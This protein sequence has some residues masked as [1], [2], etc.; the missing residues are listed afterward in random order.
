MAVVLTGARIALLSFAVGG[1][2]AAQPIPPLVELQTIHDGKLS[3]L[4]VGAV[5]VGNCFSPV[6]LREMKEVAVLTVSVNGP[7]ERSAEH[8]A[9]QKAAEAGANCLQPLAS[10]GPEEHY[11]VVR[12]YRAFLVTTSITTID[13]TF[14]LPASPKAFEPPPQ[15]PAPLAAA[16][17]APAPAAPP[18][19]AGEEL[20]LAR[21]PESEESLWVEGPH[22]IAHEIVLDLRKITPR[23]WESIRRDVGKFFPAS[24]FETLKKARREGGSVSIDLRKRTIDLLGDD[25]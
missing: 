14:R 7:W 6:A 9:K 24:D 18:E 15:P 2:A 19:P 13:G 5:G 17:P 22:I 16:F 23:G 25:F 1:P 21:S 4:P 10:Y 11:P 3:S 12:Q 20:L 8:L